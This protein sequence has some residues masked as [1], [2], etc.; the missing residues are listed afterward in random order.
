VPWSPSQNRLF[1][2]ASKNPEVAK[3]KG[4]PM[5]TAK[6]LASEGIK[7]KKNKLSEKAKK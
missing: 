3:E 5:E 4:I 6:R 7:R 2:L 1:W